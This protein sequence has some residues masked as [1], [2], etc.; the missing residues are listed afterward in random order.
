VLAR[1]PPGG[2]VMTGAGYIY[3]I[4]VVQDCRIRLALNAEKPLGHLMYLF[5]IIF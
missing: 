4:Y 3:Q 2:K 1:K 5:Y